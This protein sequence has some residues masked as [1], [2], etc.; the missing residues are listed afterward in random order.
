MTSTRPIFAVHSRGLTLAAPLLALGLA[1][2][3][4]DAAAVCSNGDLLDC[5]P[6]GQ[7]L[8]PAARCVDPN[9]PPGY[10]QCAGFI[11]TAQD[12]VNRFWE[13]NCLPFKCGQLWLRL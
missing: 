4:G 12:D 9:P 1:L 10:T 3:P 11:N 13:N 8:N 5:N 6:V 2:T 7:T